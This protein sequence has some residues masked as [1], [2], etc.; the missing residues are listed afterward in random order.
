MT[1]A[2][3]P[4]T[5]S[6]RQ[7][8]RLSGPR[9][10]SARTDAGARLRTA[11]DRPAFTL[12]EVLI[13]LALLATV[14]AA[15]APAALRVFEGYGLKRSAEAVRDDLT[16]A[17]LS[18]VQEGVEYHFRT[19]PGGARWVVIPGERE[20]AAAEGAPPAYVPVRSGVLAAGVTFLSDAPPGLAGG[21][22]DPALFEGLP[23]AAALA[24]LNWADPVVFLPDGT[25]ERAVVTL[26]DDGGRAMR[27]AVRPLTGAATVGP[28]EAAPSGGR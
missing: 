5:A 25:G 20:R 3:R 17:R 13:V 18:A 26:T 24:A 12:V 7:A 16:R 15:V 21:A 9:G 14:A 27:I 23:D 28:V 4:P 10:G 22:L 19:E 2:R 1:P 6:W 11:A 8:S